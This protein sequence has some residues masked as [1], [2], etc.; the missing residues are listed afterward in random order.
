MP[1]DLTLNLIECN[2]I[3]ETEINSTNAKYNTYLQQYPTFIPV[4]LNKH[5]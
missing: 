3:N 5:Y 4:I 2:W 1:D